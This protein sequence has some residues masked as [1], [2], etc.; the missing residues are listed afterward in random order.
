MGP[1]CLHFLTFPSDAD[2]GGLRTADS[3]AS[4]FSKLL[5]YVCTY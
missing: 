2:A 3:D 1:G 5:G 4:I